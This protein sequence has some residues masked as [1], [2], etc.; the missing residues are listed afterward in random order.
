V[1]IATR[2]NLVTRIDLS[3]GTEAGAPA[4][5]ILETYGITPEAQKLFDLAH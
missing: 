2:D 1:K 4:Q 5:T 3:A